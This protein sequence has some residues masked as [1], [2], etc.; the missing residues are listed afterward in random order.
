MGTNG[1]DL[2]QKRPGTGKDEDEAFGNT[3]EAHT[4]AGLCHFSALLGVIWWIP[5][6]SLWL[7]VGHLLCPLVV[8]IYK[9]K[10][11]PWIDFAGREAVNF[12]TAM[13]VYGAVGGFLLSGTAAALWLW[14]VA[15]T[16]L[17]WIIRGGVQAS[18]GRFF[19]YPLIPWRLLPEPRSVT[20][21]RTRY[22]HLF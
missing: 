22:P 11:S 19:T 21:L 14:C 12:Q 3:D 9:R 20:A 6:S 7:P 8:W 17:F 5:A 16:D 4:W 2:E 13:T 18:H 15:L 10:D 1:E